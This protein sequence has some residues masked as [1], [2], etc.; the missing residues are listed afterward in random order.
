MSRRALYWRTAIATAIVMISAGIALAD[1][2]S[3]PSDDGASASDSDSHC[4]L[5]PKI[6]NP[7][8][9]QKGSSSQ[10]SDWRSVAWI[11]PIAGRCGPPGTP[12][13]GTW[14]PITNQPK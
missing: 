10:D 6:A 4:S 2:P 5:K 11:C 9:S 7:D 12:G 13:L 3:K 8:S 1:C 14:E